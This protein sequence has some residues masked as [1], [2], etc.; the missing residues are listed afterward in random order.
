MNATETGTNV[1]D[2]RRAIA[3]RLASTSPT[4]ALDARLL[5]AHAIGI[6]PHEIIRHDVDAVP[7]ETRD[8]A[9]ALAERRRRGEPVA[10]IVGTKEF[11]GLSFALGPDTLVPRPDTETVVDAVLAF[12]DAGAG[13]GAPLGILDLGTGSGA[14]L[15]AL[16]SELPVAHGPGIDISPGAV[17]VAEANAAQ[18]GLSARATFRVG[19]WTREIAEQ[20]A[21]VVSNPPYIE[22]GVIAGLPVAVRDH[23]PRR[24]L[25]GGYDGLD[26]VRAVL[27]GLDAVLADGG[28]AFIEIGA[29][30]ADA[31][32]ALAD[33]RQ[34]AATFRRDLAGIERVAV[35]TRS[36]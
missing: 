2:L 10:R 14:I 15:L 30:Q 26:A 18:L 4:A 27:D 8:A 9:M 31:V 35:L 11:Y 22:T 5:V 29:G 21:I 25:D 20:F 17:A 33:A 12:V 13:R 24:A 16:L 19:D 34:F 23:D 7:A 32:R 6:S 3:E 28:A 36:K 1:G